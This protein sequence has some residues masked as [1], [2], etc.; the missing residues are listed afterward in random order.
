MAST[1][2]G[3]CGRLTH[4]TEFSKEVENDTYDVKI[5]EQA[6][7]CDNCGRMNML[8]SIQ[9]TRAS[10]SVHAFTGREEWYPRPGERKAFADVPEHIADAAS[11]ATLCFSIGAY[12]ATGSLARAVV[13]ATA[14]EEGAEG[15]DLYQRIE[16]LAESGD[17][18]KHTKDQAHEVRHFGNGMAHGDFTD[19]VTQEEAAEVVELMSEILD[20][21]FQSPARLERVREARKAN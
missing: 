1:T 19:P 11:E 2:C 8:S 10:Y 9:P 4:M 5:T 15:R 6:F 16:A 20:E 12:R 7:I 3:R 18:R 14:K 17:I 21:V 13:E